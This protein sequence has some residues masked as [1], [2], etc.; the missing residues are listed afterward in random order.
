MVVPFII[1][2]SPRHQ[3]LSNP[4][5]F[6]VGVLL[7]DKT[8]SN[9]D[10]ETDVLWI[11]CCG[12]SEPHDLSAIADQ[13]LTCSPIDCSILNSKISENN[14]C[15]ELPTLNQSCSGIMAYCVLDEH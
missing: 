14:T 5:V 6:W 12:M 2:S 13:I 4:K 3:I 10:Y 9:A 7:D 15:H 1:T 8:P 11:R